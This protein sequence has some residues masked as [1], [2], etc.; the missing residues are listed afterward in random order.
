MLRG[1]FLDHTPHSQKQTWESGKT[2]R[3]ESDSPPAGP[4]IEA[5]GVMRF[6]ACDAT[7]ESPICSALLLLFWCSFAFIVNFMFMECHLPSCMY[8]G[9]NGSKQHADGSRASDA[10]HVPLRSAK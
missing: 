2:S 7:D 4:I 9:A 3:A 8:E 5:G 1:S 6:R 10:W